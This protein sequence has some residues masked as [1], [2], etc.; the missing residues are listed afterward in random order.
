LER[1]LNSIE[2]DGKKP[3]RLML[4][5]AELFGYQCSP[6]GKILKMEHLAKNPSLLII[7]PFQTILNFFE[8]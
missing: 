8:Y 5:V 4:A 7:E 2:S 1:I 6:F 3:P